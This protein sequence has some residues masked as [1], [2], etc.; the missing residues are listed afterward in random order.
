MHHPALA[1]INLLHLPP[2]HVII[3]HP[4]IR[5]YTLPA[6]LFLLLFHLLLPNHTRNS[7][8]LGQLLQ[9]LLVVPPIDL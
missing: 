7:S 5:H 3:I 1:H 2:V 6:L 4:Q 8:H 9:L